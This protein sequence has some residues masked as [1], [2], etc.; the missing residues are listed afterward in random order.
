M[1]VWS[2]FLSFGPASDCYRYGSSWAGFLRDLY[3]PPAAPARRPAAPPHKNALPSATVTVAV[4][5]TLNPTP[6]RPVARSLPRS[7]T[8]A[9][10]L[11]RAADADEGGIPRP[12]KAR[13]LWGGEEAVRSGAVPQL[14]SQVR[15]NPQ[16]SLG[17]ALMAG[18]AR[19]HLRGCRPSHGTLLG[20][21]SKSKRGVGF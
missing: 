6:E 4:T 15:L 19:P 14:M 20:S 16:A 10:K 21:P 5:G 7:P 2:S 11:P 3:G 1:G 8:P 9:L 18:E 17:R 12:A 13:Q